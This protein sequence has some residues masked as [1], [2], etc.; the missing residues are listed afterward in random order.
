MG[1][2]GEK[3]QG[4]QKIQERGFKVTL[5]RFVDVILFG[6]GF[7]IL[8]FSMLTFITMA[9]SFALSAN[10]ATV[11][12]MSCVLYSTAINDTSNIALGNSGTCVVV[13]ITPIIVWAVVIP[14]MAYLILKL[15]QAW[16]LNCLV[17]IWALINGTLFFY[18]LAVAL[19]LTI[20]EQ[21][22]C[23]AVATLP[24]PIGG[25]Q[26]CSQGGAY[27]NSTLGFDGFLRFDDLIDTAE[28]GL[29][30]STI[31]LLIVLVIY[32]FRCILWTFRCCRKTTSKK[33]KG[34]KV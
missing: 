7:I 13:L 28:V 9:S 34:S 10:R 16:N 1:E 19:V 14:F 4:K 29:W 18:V 26:D 8:L 21:V 31:F 2:E 15:W 24:H 25:Q 12:G 17:Y 33:V 11:P 20:G 30:I 27:T 32:V 23:N 5:G 22:T 3:K 6:L